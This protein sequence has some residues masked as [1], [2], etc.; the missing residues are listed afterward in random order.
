[1]KRIVLCGLLLASFIGS[2][3][4]CL[5]QHAKTDRIAASKSVTTSPAAIPELFQLW[6]T[7]PLSRK[8]ADVSYELAN[9]YLNGFKV[10]SCLFYAQQLRQICLQLH[11]RPGIGKYHLAYAGASY[12]R[13]WTEQVSNHLD[14]AIGIFQSEQSDLYLGL[15]Y[16]LK[17]RQ[18]GQLN[19]NTN[20]QHYYRK[21]IEHIRKSGDQNYLQRA[22]HDFGRNF[23]FSYEVDSAVLYL[24]EALKMAEQMSNPAKVFNSAATLGAVYL[25]ANQLDDAAR[26]FDHALNIK[27]PE[28]DKV[29]TRSLLANYTE[30]LILQQRFSEAEKMLAEHDKLNAQLNDVTGQVNHNKLKGL[31]LLSQDGSKQALPY[32]QEAYNLKEK[33]GKA[34]FDFATI[35]LYL[36]L[37][38][39]KENR[40]NQAIGHFHYARSL[41][42]KYQ[43]PATAMDA[44]RLLA[45]AYS[46]LGQNDSA[47]YYFRVYTALKDSVYKDQRDKTILVLNA[48]Y[49]A[50]RKEYQIK[51]LQRE[52][53]LQ[54]KTIQSQQLL[55]EQRR[56]QLALISQQAEV[57]RLRSSEQS[58]ALQNRNKE[59]LQKQK[60][61]E[62]ARNENKLQQELANKETQ[63]KRL[64]L[65]IIVAGIVFGCFG[66]YRYRQTEK[67]RRQL[68][69]SLVELRQ[70]Q[71]Q[72]IQI[73]KQ[74]EA[75]NIRQRISR[76][77][78]DEVGATLS[79]V[80]LFS[81]IAI[82]KIDTEKNKDAGE[83]LTHIYSNSK[84]ML[85]KMS[86]IV[87][88]INPKND[89]FERIVFKLKTYA[90]ELCAGKGITLHF[91]IEEALT[92]CGTAMQTRKN[93]YLLAK[94]ALNNAIKYSMANNIYFTMRRK[95]GNLKIE[96]RDDGRG[97]EPDDAAGN[98]I[99]NMRARAKELGT[100]LMITSVAGKGTS[101]SLQFQF[102]PVEV[103][104]ALPA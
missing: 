59:F 81:E 102:H 98:G 51:E 40:V 96:I 61:L 95:G 18:L 17:G 28:A 97:F 11:Y 42:A 1:M 63:N 33:L 75:Q 15:S 30:L 80:V 27:P 23:F 86:D 58:L 93:I 25:L 8:K 55:A 13:G 71:Q 100:E 99:G 62:V 67:M 39:M 34:D 35:A 10:D 82:Q 22:L 7:T 32:L 90:R 47:Y 20:A 4:L 14:T 44:D 70:A 60:E 68:A 101:V 52:S 92:Q 48:K 65:A 88:A 9:A 56:Q 53:I 74:N 12:L 91:D 49:D 31:L 85:E 73:E 72:L 104:V 38:E 103:P 57:N 54:D 46:Q 64:L 79:G 19:D 6:Q 87:W 50:E 43:F 24:S 21:G 16:R 29:Q 84:D 76:D 69:A 5:S 36:G 94:E 78:H 66:V 3:Q 89:S 37:C 2:S 41:S 83:Y 26:N 77:I 45:E